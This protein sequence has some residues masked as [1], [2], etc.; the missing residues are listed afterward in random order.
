MLLY[1]T[2]GER[3]KGGAATSV[4]QDPAGRGSE[5]EPGL[6]SPPRAGAPTHPLTDLLTHFVLLNTSFPGGSPADKVSKPRRLPSTRRA[7]TSDELTRINLAV[8]AGGK[9]GSSRL[10]ERS[11]VSQSTRAA[12]TS[13]R[14]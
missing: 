2:S 7:L 14:R 10:A 13:H 4:R 5:I 12:R 6:P 9:P 3:P 8:R 1:P 11:W